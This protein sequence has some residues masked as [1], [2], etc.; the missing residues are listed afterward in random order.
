MCGTEIPIKYTYVLCDDN[1]ATY[2]KE[3]H[4]NICEV[5][6]H[7]LFFVLFFCSN[8]TLLNVDSARL[9]PYTHIWMSQMKGYIHIMKPNLLFFVVVLSKIIPKNISLLFLFVQLNDI[10]NRIN[11]KL[12]CSSRDSHVIYVDR[13]NITKYMLFGM[14]NTKSHTCW[15]LGTKQNQIYKPQTIVGEEYKKN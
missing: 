7:P 8:D 9:F 14:I 15:M 13:D 11:V 5:F 12:W 6:F 4:L 10:F 3:A 2:V 1:N